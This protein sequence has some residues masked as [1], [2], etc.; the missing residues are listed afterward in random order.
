[1]KGLAIMTTLL[2]VAS[3]ASA[4]NTSWSQTWTSDSEHKEFAYALLERTEDGGSLS[5]WGTERDKEELMSKRDQADD[6]F[7]WMRSGSMRYLVTDAATIARAREIMG[8]ELEI[9][10]SQSQLGVIQSRLGTTQSEVGVE[11][12]HLGVRQAQIGMELARI[13]LERARPGTSVAREDELER[14]G[15]ALAAELEELSRAQENLGSKQS[16]MGDDQS[17]LGDA[18]TREAERRKE[19][20]AAVRSQMKGLLSQAIASGAARRI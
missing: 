18:Q 11:Q 6:S 5:L 3:S 10:R 16:H 4:K 8:P 20:C 17:K 15:A 1:M 19:V 13:A 12:G 9:S 14:E 2:L 7:V